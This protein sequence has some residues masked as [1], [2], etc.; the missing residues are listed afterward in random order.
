MWMR[1]QVSVLLLLL[2]LLLPWMLLLLLLLLSLCMYAVYVIVCTLYQGL[3]TMWKHHLQSVCCSV[4]D[5]F[6]LHC[7]S[8]HWLE[9]SH[10]WS[11]HMAGVL[12]ANEDEILSLTCFSQLP[13]LLGCRR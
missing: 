11:S 1:P 4:L 10:G 12:T 3:T 2:L 7:W 13:L 9:F 5:L 6:W 8:S